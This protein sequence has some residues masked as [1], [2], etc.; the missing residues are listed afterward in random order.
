MQATHRHLLMFAT[1]V[2]AAPL[3]EA[4][5][6]NAH[7][8]ALQAFVHPFAG[9]DHVAAMLV[10]GLWA[11]LAAPA[12]RL[13]APLAFVGGLVGGAAL[14][15]LGVAMPAVETGIALS[16]LLLGP[17]AARDARLPALLSFA[18]CALAGVFHGH[19]HGVELSGQGWAG[20]CFVLGSVLLHGIGY[21]I[22]RHAGRSGRVATLRSALSASGVLGLGLMWLA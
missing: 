11:G 16:V 21:G 20:A 9:I 22:A 5:P 8:D 13:L 12:R 19:A 2:L 17:L 18:A 14:G 15:A 1:A 3:A 4:H 10:I 6:L 7:G